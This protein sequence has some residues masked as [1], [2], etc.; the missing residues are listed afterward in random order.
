MSVQTDHVF[1][2]YLRYIHA[3][4]VKLTKD[5]NN[6][7][8][9]PLNLGQFLKKKKEFQLQTLAIIPYYIN[10]SIEMDQKQNINSVYQRNFS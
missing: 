4:S 1:L 10:H 6:I 7:L 9:I 3:I 2:I 8:I 5:N